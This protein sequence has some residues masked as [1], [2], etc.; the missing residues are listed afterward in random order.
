MTE[1]LD[2]KQKSTEQ[3][4]IV[5]IGLVAALRIGNAFDSINVV[6]LRRAQL[7]PDP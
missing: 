4:L 1:S 3:N 5:L 2:V 7:V 6:T